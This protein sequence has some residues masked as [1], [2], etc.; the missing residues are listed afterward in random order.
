MGFK[1]MSPKADPVLCFPDK[2]SGGTDEKGFLEGRK[3]DYPVTR[4]E[5]T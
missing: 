1:I 5:L 4:R 2:R 3:R